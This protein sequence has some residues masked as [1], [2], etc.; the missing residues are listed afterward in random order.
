MLRRT[1]NPLRCSRCGRSHDD[2]ADK[3]AWNGDFDR[4]VLRAVICPGCQTAAE[5]V[6]AAA[7]E[8][9]VD[10]STISHTADG[11]VQVLEPGS[12]TRVE[13]AAHPLVQDDPDV[14][15]AIAAR[16][17][18][19][20]ISVASHSDA[21][22]VSA[23]A[24]GPC[25]QVATV[26]LMQAGAVARGRHVTVQAVDTMTV[27]TAIL[28]ADHAALTDCEDR[29]ELVLLF[30]P[31]IDPAL[32]RAFAPDVASAMR[33]QLAAPAVSGDGRALPS[34]RSAGTDLTAVGLVDSGPAW[35]NFWF[36]SVD[37]GYDLEAG[38]MSW[39]HRI[40]AD[41]G[42]STVLSAGHGLTWTE[43]PLEHRSQLHIPAAGDGPGL[44][45]ATLL[46]STREADWQWDRTFARVTP[47]RLSP[48]LRGLLPTH[49]SAL[50]AG[51]VTAADFQPDR[52]RSP[53]TRLA[54]RIAALA[55][56][57][58]YLAIDSSHF[59][60]AGLALDVATT[61]ELDADSHQNLRLPGGWSLVHHEPVPVR[62]IAAG[63][64]ELEVM[65]AHG[66]VVGREQ[67]VLGR[68][69]GRD[70]SVRFTLAAG[71]DPVDR[72]V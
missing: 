55:T 37:S 70:Q 31:D 1:A 20:L 29:G 43:L 52:R 10:S 71:P 44:S 4:G 50:R 46:L 26:A 34:P 45:L 33:S 67:A 57:A 16:H 30:H 21:G 51:L 2:A 8:V 14:H 6:E 19:L 24:P 35:Q 49:V 36:G 15:L 54:H 11:R 61:A 68:V 38:L 47:D 56:T 62:V 12:W 48:D 42:A 9:L 3:T 39:T 40:M 66:V 17:G 53:A 64:D 65:T 27:D 22:L 41:S 23:L 18:A 32:L 60:P 69:F 63:D 72:G 25:T 7:N 59:I 28:A 13:A 58:A 5:A